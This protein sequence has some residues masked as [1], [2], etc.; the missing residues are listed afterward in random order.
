MPR[1][2]CVQGVSLVKEDVEIE[3]GGQH[4]QICFLV[5]QGIKT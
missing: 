4:Q 2:G 5:Y 3:W 1:L